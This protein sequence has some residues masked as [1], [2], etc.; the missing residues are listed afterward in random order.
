VRRWTQGPEAPP[1][2]EERPLLTTN[3]HTHDVHDDTLVP[4]RRSPL[5]GVQELFVLS[6]ES[7]QIL[8]D[9][10]VSTAVSCAGWILFVQGLAGLHGLAFKYFMKEDLHVSPATLTFVQ[11]LATLPW[12]IKPVYGFT[13]DAVPILGYRRKPYL[14]LAG[15]LGCVS[16]LCMAEFVED[17]Y[18]ATVCLTVPSLAAA[19][20]NVMAEA[21]VVEKSRGRSQ[22]YA[23]RLQTCIYGGREAGAI[24]SSF[25]G[26]WLLSFMTARHVFLLSSLIPLSLILVA[27]AVR[28]EGSSDASYDADE[29]K[30]NMRKLYR[31]FR[32]PRIWQ[33]VAFLFF[34]NVTPSAGEVWFYF[35][36]DVTKFSS[37]FLGTMHLAGS[38]FS[39]LG[40]FF[41]DATLRKVPFLPIFIGG[42]I[43]SVAFGLTQLFLILRWNLAWGIPDEAFAL[44]EASIQG[45]IG[46]VCSMP[47]FV[48]AARLCPK[49]MEATMYACCCCC[50]CY[51]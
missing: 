5:S 32:H 3:T 25:A 19:F 48:L 29:V 22:E 36:T 41:F 11:S 44:G 7:E 46:W 2:L 39:L 21:L 49:G 20:A 23:G 30:S 10:S 37:T 28:E 50:C 9:P 26:G 1:A 8:A 38:I 6:Q 4:S 14:L 15:L 40:V 43:L 24:C 47:I 51:N 31:T 35:Y 42:I 34:F 12:V 45:V 16:W 33:P 27:C 17:V 13:S 18:A